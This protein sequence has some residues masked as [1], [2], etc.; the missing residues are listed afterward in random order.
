META[1]G[2][3]AN[4]A[5]SFA[6]IPE[7]SEPGPLASRYEPLAGRPFAYV[8]VLSVAMLTMLPASVRNVKPPGVDATYVPLTAMVPDGTVTATPL[9]LT[10]RARIAVGAPCAVP[11]TS[12]DSPTNGAGPSMTVSC[13]SVTLTS[14]PSTACIKN[15]VAD[16]TALTAPVTVMSCCTGMPGCAG[17]TLGEPPPPPPH[18]AKTLVISTSAV[19]CTRPRE[20]VIRTPSLK[21]GGS[22]LTLSE[23]W[24]NLFKLGCQAGKQPMRL[25]R[26]G[27]LTPFC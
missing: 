18:A 4:N 13:E 26:L 9:G 23:H 15:A 16:C 17:R 21:R 12:T 5:T 20:W 7:D 8:V 6:V 10:L 1:G 19:N 24:D 25:R 22:T 2:V 14:L 27:L 11:E 3:A